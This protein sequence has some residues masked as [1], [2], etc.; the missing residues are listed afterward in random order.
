MLYRVHDS[1]GHQ[2][3][4][5]GFEHENGRLQRHGVVDL[6]DR[7]VDAP[8]QRHGSGHVRWAEHD[9]RDSDRLSV[10]LSEQLRV[11]NTGTADLTL[12]AFLSPRFAKSA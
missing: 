12:P 7:T 8:G 2:V 11:R 5:P 4:S 1:G 3:N 6:V 10:Q 9:H